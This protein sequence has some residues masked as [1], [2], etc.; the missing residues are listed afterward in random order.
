MAEPKRTAD[1]TP[2][3]NLNLFVVA[4]EHSGDALGAKLMAA[5]NARPDVRIQYS[6]VGGEGMAAHGLTSLSA[7]RGCRDGADVDPAAAAPDRAAGL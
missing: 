2:T 3:G 1:R 7:G 5:L 6:G 4:G